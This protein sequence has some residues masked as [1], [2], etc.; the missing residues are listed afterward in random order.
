[1]NN[2]KLKPRCVQIGIQNV[3]FDTAIKNYIKTVHQSNR[4]L[5]KT[6][7]DLELSH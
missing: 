1:M 7:G 6:E 2:N 5:R 3:W 4:E